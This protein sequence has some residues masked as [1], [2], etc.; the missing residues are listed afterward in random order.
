MQRLWSFDPRHFS[1]HSALS[2]YELF[3]TLALGGSSL[4]DLW[5][6]PWGVSRILGLRGHC[7]CSHSSKGVG[8]Q[9]KII[10]I[11]SLRGKTAIFVM[12]LNTLGGCE[13]LTSTTD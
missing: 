5:S 2:L 9:Q 10:S 13:K 12:V 8:L 1:S 7:P 3:A 11:P 4:Y 6:R